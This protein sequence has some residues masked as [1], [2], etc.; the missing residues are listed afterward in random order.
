MVDHKDCQ[1]L[2]S[3]LTYHYLLCKL[4]DTPQKEMLT[5][6]AAGTIYLP[7]H[8]HF[9]IA[10][11]CAQCHC[12]FTIMDDLEFK[13]LLQ[14]LY[15]KVKLLSCHVISCD[16]KIIVNFTK[17]QVVNI[18]KVSTEFVLLCLVHKLTV[19]LP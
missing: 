6:Y 12:P 11:W 1:D 19:L 15:I 9:L 2:T 14:M 4:E 13:S 8:I 7:L 17:G 5:V 18:F 16:I 10:T 3:N